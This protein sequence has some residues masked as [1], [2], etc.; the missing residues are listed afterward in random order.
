[1]E[2]PLS[3]LLWNVAKSHITKA[4]TFVAGVLVAKG[5][6]EENQSSALVSGFV[7]I[8]M[9]IAV[10]L[11]SSA[12]TIWQRYKDQIKLMIAARLPAGSSLETVNEAAKTNTTP[13]KLMVLLL[14]VGI[15]GSLAMGCAMRG[16]PP[17]RQVAIISLQVISGVDAVAKTS[18]E[19]HASKVLTD[20]QYKAVVVR[21]REVY[22][23]T[24]R[25]ADA[26]KAYDTVASTDAASQVT[27]ALNALA[28][29][30]PN[31]ASDLTGPGGQKIAALVGEV[32]KLL[33]AIAQA[34][35]P[36][37]TARVTVELQPVGG[38]L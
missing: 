1:M 13:L 3:Q 9:G 19:L 29:L 33:I 28:V 15:S 27:A 35:R 26:L 4:I 17:E 30:V 8:G 6:I 20:E 21:L 31:L 18:Q 25:L 22:L 2:S 34:V 38:V 12:L 37:T 16:K 24:S 23:Q 7:E 5:V 11:V 14:A 10:F 36:A 32:N